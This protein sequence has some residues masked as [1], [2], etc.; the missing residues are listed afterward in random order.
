VPRADQIPEPMPKG[1]PYGENDDAQE[2]ASMLD[3]EEEYT[4]SSPEE[5]FLLSPYD[6]PAEPL[7]AGAPFGP[8]PDASRYAVA[9]DQDV[10]RQVAEK[11]ASDPMS[12]STAKAWARRR[13]TGQ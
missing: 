9:R 11:I 4:P 7:T 10:L 5:E 13:L 2:L 3:D 8:G 6:R 1:L 12:D